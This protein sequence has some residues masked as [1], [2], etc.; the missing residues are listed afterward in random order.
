MKFGLIKP[1]LTEPK[2]KPPENVCS[3]FL[4]NEGVEFVTIAR[5]LRNPEIGSQRSN[6]RSHHQLNIS[7][8]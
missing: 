8:N 6:I 5:I 1:S 2:R 7:S 3:I 4:E